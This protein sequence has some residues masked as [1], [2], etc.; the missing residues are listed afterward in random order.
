M[1]ANFK[2][3][4]GS[5]YG[6][7]I[8]DNSSGNTISFVAT[9]KTDPFLGFALYIAGTGNDYNQ[10]INCNLHNW[11]QYGTGVFTT[12]RSTADTLPGSST[13]IGDFSAIG[14]G[15]VAGFNMV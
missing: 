10:I 5:C 6:I 4:N 14:T 8:D 2:Y 11:A 15:S 9:G 3:N 1:C 13:T 12:D 7:Y